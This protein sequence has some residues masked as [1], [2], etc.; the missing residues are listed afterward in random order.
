MET[1]T[2]AAAMPR[3]VTREAWRRERI[4]LL[5]REKELTRARDAVSAARRRL[6]MVEVDAPYTF[7]TAR[8]P[9]SLADLFDGRRQL[10]VY[11]FMFDPAWEQGCPSC[12]LLADNIGHLS[13]LHARGTSLVLVSRAPLERIE[14]FRARMGW[15][16]P[17]AS[18]HGTT[19]NHDFHATAD[20]EVAPPEYN[21]R[22]A[23]GHRGELPGVSVFL[24]DGDRVFHTYSAYARG[25]EP[26]MGTFTWL[27]LTPF[28]RQE[29]WEDSPEG[30]PRTATY[31]WARH[32]DRYEG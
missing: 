8:G 12:S 16:L 31:G 2:T 14:A 7:Q 27:D 15:T 25:V 13:H 11:H 21:Y 1:E 17:W 18:S 22:P 26:L 6:P 5:A 19:F 10:A 9:A 3:V 23:P 24:R 4:A 30:W 32:H 20:E 28:G 29:E